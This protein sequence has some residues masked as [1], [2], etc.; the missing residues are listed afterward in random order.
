MKNLKDAEHMK[1][2]LGNPKNEQEKVIFEAIVEFI[3]SEEDANEEIQWLP[4]KIEK[5]TKNCH[6]IMKGYKCNR[7]EN[8]EFVK[9]RYCS[10]CG[11]YFN[12][13]VFKFLDNHR[14]SKNGNYRKS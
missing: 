1:S 14:R 10:N 5:R 11:G 4:D 6:S 8:F 2:R 7:C 9:K 12:G 3:D 13:E